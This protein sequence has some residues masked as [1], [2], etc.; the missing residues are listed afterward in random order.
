MAQTTHPQNLAALDIETKCAVEGCTKKAAHDHG[1]IPH[2]A[3][4]TCVGVV[5]DTARQVFRSP[6]ELRRYLSE[7]P[8]QLFIGQNFKF[9]M[10][11]LN[12]SWGID[13]YDRWWGDTQLAGATCLDKPNAKWFAQYETQRV[14]LNKELP[15]GFEHRKASPNSLKVL[16]PYHLGVAPF[17]E[18]PLDHDSDEYVLKD[19]QY[20]F[21]LHQ[22]L[23]EKLADQQLTEFY[24]NR[25]MPWARMLGRAERRGV[26]IDLDRID[27]LDQGARSEAGLTKLDLIEDL[28]AAWGEYKKKLEVKVHQK[29]GAMLKAALKKAKNKEK[30]RARYASLKKNAMKKLPGWFNLNSDDQ[31]AWILR[32]F[33]GLD[34]KNFDGDDTTGKETL[35]KLSRQGVG[36]AD[37]LLKYRKAEKLAT[38]FFPT[39]RKLH[40][41]GSLHCSF[42]VAG[43]RTGRLSCSSPNLQQVPGHIKD[44]F[45]ARPGYVFITRDLAAIE[46]ALAAYYTED[47]ELYNAVHSDFHGKNAK[48]MFGLDCDATEVKGRYDL[49]RRIAKTCGLALLYGASAGRIQAT[50][51][52]F[53]LDWSD[54]KCVE[55]FNRFKKTYWRSYEFKAALDYRART[56]AIT[57]LLGR[58]HV[59]P[60][61]RDI[62]MK[63]FN[64]LIQSSASDLM[65]HSSHKATEHFES[66][67][68]DCVP[69]L[70][71]HDEAVFEAPETHADYCASKIDEYI[72]RHVL[73]TQHGPIPLKT[74]GN[75]APYWSK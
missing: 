58:K 74:E 59:Y 67:S 56:E 28:W 27:S 42:N 32:D 22:R 13:L 48:V 14:K 23:L 21:D 41:N 11:H 71:V 57:N 69:L 10:A 20:T 29:Y 36:I 53:G 66:L 8:Y 62:F 31:V 63:A 25:L 19:C 54:E 64:T 47:I 43:T 37:K 44:I 18:N 70:F 15:K 39:Y 55:I 46:P 4:I 9:D 50:A 35:K 1:L 73:N 3:K 2:M 38:S 17:W 52:S 26:L 49:E 33:Y 65:I 51:T 40:R 16:A 6:R 12:Y 34:I 7:N 24:T 68:I 72:T 5:S 60:N 45:R 75:I 30:C 61:P